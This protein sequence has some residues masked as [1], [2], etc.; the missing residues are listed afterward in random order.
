MIP[1]VKIRRYI[2]PV[3]MVAVGVGLSVLAFLVVN[4]REYREMK[5]SFEQH[6]VE[7]YDSLKREIEFDLQTLETITV[8]YQ[9]S[10]EVDRSEFRSFVKPLL[11]RH[12]S[13]QA[14]EWIPRVPTSQRE[15][16]EE[17]AK[18]DGFP[19]FQI[20]ERDT[21]GG[22]VRAR[23]RDEYF[24]VY[25][26]E[27]YK[28]NE[29]ALGFDLASN[30][31][32]EASLSLARDTGKTTA[33]SRVTLVQETANQSGFLVFA[34]VY[35]KHV[36][37]ASSEDRRKNLMGFVLGVFRISNIMEHSLAYLSPERINV[38]L[39]DQSAPENDRFLYSSS[40]RTAETTASPMSNRDDG[41]HK[42]FRYVGAIDVAGRPWI[43]VLTPT[44]GYLA[45]RRSWQPW[46]ALAAGLLF[47]AFLAAYLFISIGRA[48]R[49]ERLV[50]ERTR[51]LAQA[52][53]DLHTE[54]IERKQAEEA[55]RDSEERYRIAIENSNDGVAII[56]E[57]R[58]VYVN[59]RFLEMFGYDGPEEVLG[60]S[61]ADSRHVH[62][63]D[64]KMVIAINR[65]RAEGKPE[66]S[67]YDYRAVHRDGRVLHVEISATTIIYQ[68][69]PSS[70]VYL[71]DVTDRRQAEAALRESEIKYRRIFESLDDL[72]YQ[73]DAQ[74]I[75]RVVSPSS[76]RLAGWTPEELIGRPVA[77]VYVDPSTR[78]DLLRHL[79]QHR[80]VKDYEVQLKKKDGTI[81]HVSVGAQLLYDDEGNPNGVSG[82]LRDISERIE[83][84]E[85]IRRTNLQ[86]EAA[87]ARANDMAAQAERA[88][89]AKSMFLANMSHEI[90]TP[91]SGVLGMTRL[92]LGTP[93]NDRQRNYA[94][95]IK[96]SG[97]LLLSVINNVLDFS[98]IEAGK[99]RV[100]Q[101][102]FSLAEVMGNV[103]DAFGP[104]AEEKGIALH[105][106][107]DPAIPVSLLG[108]PLRLTQ[109]MNNLM[110]NA[111][112]FTQ[113]GEIHLAARVV[114]K[115]TEHVDLEF[116][117]GDTG[118]GITEEEMA[119]I[120]LPFSQADESTTRRFG[121]SGLGLSIS[122]HLCELMG[123]T[124]RGE[125][126][127]G[128]G[129][130]FTVNIPFRLLAGHE[131]A[132]KPDSLESGRVALRFK[133]VRALVVEDVDINLEITVEMLRNMDIAVDTAQNGR[134]AVDMVKTGNY[135]IIFMDIQMPVMDGYEATREI[136]QLNKERG[137]GLPIIAM[138]AHASGGDRDKS[139]AA[140]MNEHLTKPVDPEKLG[141]VLEHWLPA[142]M[143]VVISGDEPGST[144]S[145]SDPLLT[146]YVPGLDVEAALRR[147]NGNR[148]LYLNL[149]EKFVDGYADTGEQLLH[150]LRTD[151]LEQAIRRV[152][153]IKSTAGN[154]GGKELEAVAAELEKA[155]R[156]KGSVHFSLGEPVR[157][158]I[159]RHNDLL[160]A[161]AAAL[162]PRQAGDQTRPERQRGMADEYLQLL[163]RLRAALVKNEPRPAMDILAVLMQKQWPGVNDSSLTELNRLL[164]RYRFDEAMSILDSLSGSLDKN[165]KGKNDD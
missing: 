99:L 83:A 9:A 124:I 136:R 149:L 144:F 89:A 20:T 42:Q 64:R 45:A 98:K 14:L 3:A 46:A 92:L 40:P 120:F 147:V 156:E 122:T 119:R 41:S 22:M 159:D 132:L 131:R 76:V 34:P 157:R 137:L 95:K 69:K 97:T 151:Q 118:I 108:D 143:R 11:D 67:R 13:I 160:A 54:I 48:R 148:P 4:H 75:L 164:Q 96:T 24:P 90:R 101:I 59:Q 28:G 85:N 47:T 105:S 73:T 139:F 111:V 153:S 29:T 1:K 26:V 33:T 162:P 145:P 50:E 140:G 109:I 150:E 127:P 126:T 104:R 133:G 74:G 38:F 115:K 107:I 44:P 110:S 66:P 158:F 7:R 94:E 15:T 114:E 25:F 53:T 23:E 10:K 152:H 68:G 21:Q 61:I 103:A 12:P 60:K 129:S 72:Y 138:T 146:G 86:L 80:H 113:E 117:V 81:L 93:L 77:D 62:P 142:E 55:V 155:L 37:L 31:T 49:I 116:S 88:N 32:R 27:P 125:S 52:N 79:L 30:P 87:T 56:R 35:R 8:F 134:E 135:D 165:R 2:P 39:Y 57:D 58:H 112:K 65:G 100:E 163:D 106:S 19:G 102:P 84:E 82:T 5:L 141:E 121:G 70:L 43:A 71:R 18:R 51:D 128:K 130:L 63:E 36:L 16:Y 91:I 154:I 161:I 78:E 123:G 17:S 6:A